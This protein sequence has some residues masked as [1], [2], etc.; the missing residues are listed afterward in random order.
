M[1]LQI[2]LILGLPAALLWL[3][4]STAGDTADDRRGLRRR[5]V[6]VAFTVYLA[7][8]AT[9][10]SAVLIDFGAAVVL[11][12]V[13]GSSPRAIRWYAGRLGS[14]RSSGHEPTARSTS[15]LCREWLDSYVELNRAPSPVARLRVVMARERCLDELERRDPE[16]LHAWLASA[17]TA[18]GDPR[19]FL[20]DTNG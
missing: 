12:L 2:W 14:D 6:R 15:E 9:L 5:M 19:R 3:A 7:T 13:L 11:A 18:A 8:I 17:A 16:G 1:S 20:S 10:G 4:L